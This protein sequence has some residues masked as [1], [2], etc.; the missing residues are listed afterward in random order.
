MS[1][2]TVQ[3]SSSATP[4]TSAKGR[5]KVKYTY[6]PHRIFSSRSMAAMLR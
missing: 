1:R 4:A 5:R 2:G 6:A 3:S